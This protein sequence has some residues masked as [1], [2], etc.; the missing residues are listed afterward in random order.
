MMIARALIHNTRGVFETSETRKTWHLDIY[1]YWFAPK[2][3]IAQLSIIIGCWIEA[4]TTLFMDAHSICE[5]LLVIASFLVRSMKLPF[6]KLKALLSANRHSRWKSMSLALHHSRAHVSF[7]LSNPLI[8]AANS[9]ATWSQVDKSSQK[10]MLKWWSKAKDRRFVCTDK[11]VN[12]VERTHTHMRQMQQLNA[13]NRFLNWIKWF[14]ANFALFCMPKFVHCHLEHFNSN[15]VRF[16]L[17]LMLNQQH[18][19]I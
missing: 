18:L 5:P 19:M 14:W 11:T 6:I 10:L 9:P 7:S 16:M 2:K 8:F 3:I 1:V 17:L 15:A 13:N 12:Q 4:F